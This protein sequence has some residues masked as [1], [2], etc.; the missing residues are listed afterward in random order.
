MFFLLFIILFYYYLYLL[1][2]CSF[3]FIYSFFLGLQQLIDQ[4]DYY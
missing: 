3:Q 1:S 4:I 2:W